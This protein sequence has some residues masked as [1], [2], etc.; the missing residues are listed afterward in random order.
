MNSLLMRSALR[1]RS[2]NV[3]MKN[4]T[5][6]SRGGGF[7]KPD[8]LP[9]TSYKHTRRIHLEDMNTQFYNSIAPEF[10]FHLHSLQIQSGKRG[11]I[12][13]FLYW[14]GVLFP[15]LC[16]ARYCHSKMGAM[17]F[18]TIRPGPDHAGMMPRLLTHLQ[19]N[20][21]EKSADFFGRKNA[22]FYRNAIRQ[23]SS[24]LNLKP[25]FV[26]RLNKH[27]FSF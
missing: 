10:H 15:C 14:W 22:T 25:Y 5:I 6:A 8:P 23:E 27:G 2:G 21:M 24:N 20:D 1:C 4:A 19:A 16:V 9:Y 18:P 3:M 7:H 12:L 11:W 17:M 26:K 13:I